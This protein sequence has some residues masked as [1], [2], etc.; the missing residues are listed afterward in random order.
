S[1]VEELRVSKAEWDWVTK[2]VGDKGLKAHKLAT[3]TNRL[4]TLL[5]EAIAHLDS[6]F[7]IFCVPWRPKAHAKDKPESEWTSDDVA[8]DFTIFVQEGM[9]KAVPI[10]LYS[11]GETSMI[12]FA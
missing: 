11:C 4:N 1:K 6:S 8:L 12:S 7:S 10:E 5:A 9:K 2:N 3:L